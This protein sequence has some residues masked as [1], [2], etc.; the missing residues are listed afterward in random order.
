MPR[1]LKVISYLAP[2]FRAGLIS[3][4]VVAAVAFPLAAVGGLGLLAASDY[5]ENMPDKL[6]PAPSPQVTKVYA[7]DGKTIGSSGTAVA[8]GAAAAASCSG[9]MD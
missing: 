8:T 5:V 9:P 7:S 3:G 4:V 6:R 1:K 2:L